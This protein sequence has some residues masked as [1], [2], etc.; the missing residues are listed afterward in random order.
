[1]NGKSISTLTTTL[2]TV[3][4]KIFWLKFGNSINIQIYK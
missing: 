1:L 4:N 2:P 3:N